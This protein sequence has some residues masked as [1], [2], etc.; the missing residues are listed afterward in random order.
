MR[1]SRILAMHDIT[2]MGR[3][4]LRDEGELTLLIGKILLVFQVL[5]NVDFVIHELI[6]NVRNGR[7]TGRS[8]LI[9]FNGIKSRPAALLLILETALETSID[10]T[11]EKEKPSKS[12]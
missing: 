10:V 4:S 6:K 12:V 7:M 3:K 8:N 1:I 11:L 2:L 9:K 5:G